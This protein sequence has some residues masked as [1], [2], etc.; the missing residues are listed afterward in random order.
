MFNT[1]FRM[2]LEAIK[3]AILPMARN[4]LTPNTLEGGVMWALLAPIIA[5]GTVLSNVFG[6]S[7]LRAI[8]KIYLWLVID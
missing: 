8:G 3:R 2:L 6:V 7:L 5:V 4:R 1:P